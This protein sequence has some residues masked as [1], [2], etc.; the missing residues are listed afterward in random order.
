MKIKTLVA[1]AAT[2]AVTLSAGAARA[3]D[4]PPPP[5]VSSTLLAR[6]TADRVAPP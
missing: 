1:S 4:D 3:A 5:P 2:L 6:G